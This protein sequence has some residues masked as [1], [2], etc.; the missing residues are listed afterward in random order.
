M[1]CWV[2]TKNKI[3][4][5]AILYPEKALQYG[6]SKINSSR[7]KNSPLLLLLPNNIPLLHGSSGN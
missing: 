5:S 2:M 6:K 3:T 4:T 1:T 7:N